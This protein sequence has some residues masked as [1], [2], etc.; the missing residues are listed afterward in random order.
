MNYATWESAVY[1]FASAASLGKIRKEL[2]KKRLPKP[3]YPAPK[4]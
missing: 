3:D 4:Q 2:F 1:G